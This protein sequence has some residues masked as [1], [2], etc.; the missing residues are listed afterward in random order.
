MSAIRLLEV[1]GVVRDSLLNVRTKDIDYAVEIPY[2]VGQDAILGFDTMRE[3][4]VNQGFEIFVETPDFLTIRARFPRSDPRRASTTADFVLCRS[5]GPYSDGR[6][7]DYV[8]V[9]TLQ[10]DLGRRDFTVN[11]LARDEDGYIVDLH[12]GVRDLRDRVLRCVGDPYD[13]MREDALRAMRALRFCITKG[14]RMP[15]ELQR[16]INDGLTVEALAR[17]SVERREHELRLCFQHDTLYT[18]RWLCSTM[19]SDAFREAALL[20][21]KLNPTHK[22][23]LPGENK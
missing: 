1:G 18:L 12:H 11:A 17:I 6:R 5:E 2:M 14:F 4:L 10:D 23:R 19:F 20:G 22:R 16:V 7:P 8:R 21:I 15:V 9:G 3:F 13:R